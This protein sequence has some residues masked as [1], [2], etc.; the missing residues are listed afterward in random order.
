[1]SPLLQ[2]Y[3]EA[4][5]EGGRT[6]GE[7]PVDFSAMPELE[8]QARWFAGEFGDSWSTV[9]GAHVTIEDF[10]RWNREP[11]PD[12]VDA[13]IRIDGRP[14]R[15]A[16]ELDR[17]VR[18][19]ERHGHAANPAFRDVVLHVFTD[20]P[21]RR[22]YTRTTD[23]REIAQLRLPPFREE[24]RA[25]PTLVSS[26]FDASQTHILLAAARHRMDL[27]ARALKRCAA[28]HGDDNAWFAALGTALGYRKN[29]APFLLLAQ[30]VGLHAAGTAKGEAL[31]FGTAGFLESPPQPDA[32]RAVR[33]YLRDLWECWWTERAGCERWILPRTAWSFAGIRPANHPHRRVAALA[34]I[35]A[36]WASIRGALAH[37]RRDA[38]VGALESLAHP[39]WNT[40]YHL[41]CSRLPEP[42]SLIGTDRITDILVNILHPLA[43]ARSDR[44]W[45]DFL[46]EKGPSPAAVMRQSAARFFGSAK[47]PL[48]SAALQQGLLQLER[49]FRAASDPSAFLDALRRRVLRSVPLP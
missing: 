35:A 49:D 37:T 9:D 10:G 41:D 27:K 13:R 21:A 20:G 36:G 33:H 45:E 38:L 12:F 43:I 29:Q 5:S 18:D 15:G 8:W 11:G 22:F 39:F 34:R 30:R 48:G 4:L 40:R 31:L 6:I 23:H 14:L 17:D 19:W 24:I 32:D 47:L 3:H 26:A 7:D 1:M 44:A 46:L 2:S 42:R 16:I 28:V 25:R